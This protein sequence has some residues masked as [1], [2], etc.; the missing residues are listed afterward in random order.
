MN[1]NLFGPELPIPGLTRD[2]LR[3]LREQAL[4]YRSVG[5]YS[6][7]F[8]GAVLAVFLYTPVERN[9]LPLLAYLVGMALLCFACYTFLTNIRRHFGSYAHSLTECGDVG[10]LNHIAE[11]CLKFSSVKR[12][13]KLIM[14]HSGREKL[15]WY[16]IPFLQE[17]ARQEEIYGSLY[18]AQS[19]V[20]SAINSGKE[21]S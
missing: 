19:A 11:L 15:F 5:T 8:L 14:D 21:E 9:E 17:I 10:M 13:V 16:E 6:V 20:L 2:E 7:M 18:Q 1:K 3:E 12:H 4:F